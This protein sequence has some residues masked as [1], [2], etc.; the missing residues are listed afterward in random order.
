MI[1][2][3]GA[4]GGQGMLGG[5][6]SGQGM[7]LRGQAPAM[8]MP[9]G[10]AANN[11]QESIAFWRSKGYSDDAIAGLLAQESE[12][13]KFNPHG[14]AGDAG[15]AIGSFQWH[16]DRRARIRAAT[17]VDVTSPSTSHRQMLEAAEWELRH[18]ESRAGEHL[19]HARSAAEAGYIGSKEFE[20]AAGRFGKEREARRRGGIAER[21]KVQIHKT[22]GGNTAD[23][24]VALPAR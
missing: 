12:E 5:G 10:Q 17:G 13:S 4:G 24:M 3:R 1:G 21:M 22:P 11:M 8:K 18:S 2:L 9:A 7:D 23:Q 20:R 14:P 19:R 15:S 6:T 16:P